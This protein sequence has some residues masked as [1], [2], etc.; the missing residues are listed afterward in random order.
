MSFRINT[1]V[2]AMGAFRSLQLTGLDL[3]RSMQRLTTGM[4]INSGADDPAGLIG[5]ENFRA[6][7]VG[8]DAAIRNNQDAINYAKTAEGA[9]AEINKLLNDARGLAVSSANNATLSTAQR[10]ANQ[11]QL[12]SILASIDRISANTQ[13]GDRRLLNG[14]AGVQAQVADSAR[15]AS[16]Q[17]TGRFNGAALTTNSAITVQVTTAAT[18]AVVTGTQ[19]YAAL[20]TTVGAGSFSLNGRVFVTNEQTTV[21]ELIDKLNAASS[22]TGV[23]A[24]YSS[25]AIVLRQK[26]FGSDNR[27]ELTVA[28]A[29]LVNSAA[30]HTAAA[31]ANAAATVTIGSASVAFTAGL[32]GRDALTLVDADG[33]VVRLTQAGNVT[34]TYG[35]AGQIIVGSADF[36]IGAN[37]GQ[38]ASLS[39]GNYSSNSLGLVSLDL[40][41]AAG[42]TSALSLIDEAIA[43]VSKGR[44]DIG[45]FIRNNLESNVRALGIARENT[46][47]T[48][49][50]LR[51]VDVAEEMT[52]FTKL[53]ILQQSGLAM[54]AQANS[55]PQSVLSLL[56]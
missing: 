23:L 48:E 8:I 18:K 25:N 38:T 20:S 52:T 34:G 45:S 14:T 7:L 15:F 53:Q 11:S 30:G 47:A 16:M 2:Q 44:G 28:T 51:D 13:F 12:E 17:F 27:I 33:N 6:Q 50:S 31:G 24:S 32:A 19:T 43:R 46:A 39:I 4:R 36:Q 5:S 40:T 3:S 22:E 21:G 54:L 55:L 37:A 1:N 10:Q 49:S 29:G 42:A 35:N 41:S 56:R 26:N 9:L